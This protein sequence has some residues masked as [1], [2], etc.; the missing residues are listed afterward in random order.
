MRCFWKSYSTREYAFKLIPHSLHNTT[1]YKTHR[2]LSACFRA[3]A[4]WGAKNYVQTQ[5]AL[6]CEARN[7]S[8]LCLRQYL[9]HRK[10]NSL[11]WP[12]RLAQFD[13]NHKVF[14]ESHTTHKR[15][16]WTNSEVLNVKAFSW[17]RYADTAV[18]GETNKKIIMSCSNGHLTNQKT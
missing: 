11:Q 15:I 14:W 18:R 3:T 9:P 6:R 7:E 4:P 12:T 17:V 13:S 16:L 5:K 1:C 8:T 10:H 2:F